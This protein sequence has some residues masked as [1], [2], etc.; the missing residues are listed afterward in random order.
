MPTNF[1]FAGLTL[2]DKLSTEGGD[3]EERASDVQSTATPPVYLSKGPTLF[4]AMV[5]SRRLISAEYVLQFPIPLPDTNQLAGLQVPARM[6]EAAWAQMMAIINAYKP[7]IVKEPLA[8]EESARSA[9]QPDST[10]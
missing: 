3:N 7:S 6:S 8:R 1:A 9:L 5:E 10:S 4:G 2:A